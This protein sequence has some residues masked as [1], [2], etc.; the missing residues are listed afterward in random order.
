M[1]TSETA[2]RPCCSWPR[3]PMLL[4]FAVGLIV[5]AILLP[6]LCEDSIYSF[7]VFSTILLLCLGRWGLAALLREQS[8]VWIMYAM[9]QLLSAFLTMGIMILAQWI[10]DTIH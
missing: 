4:T 2:T 6:S 3:M 5:G 9:I 10:K 1:T 8:R 7:W